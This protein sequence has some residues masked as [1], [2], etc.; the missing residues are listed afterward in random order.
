MLR[1]TFTT[2]RSLA[3]TMKDINGDRR[4]ANCDGCPYM[5]SRPLPRAAMTMTVV[6]AIPAHGGGDAQKLSDPPKKR[7]ELRTNCP[8]GV[9]CYWHV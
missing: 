4:D 3:T 2:G 7:L 9:A 5:R 8:W 1:D 6:Q